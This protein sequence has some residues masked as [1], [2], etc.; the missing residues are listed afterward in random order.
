MAPRALILG[1]LV[2]PLLGCAGKGRVQSTSWTE[3]CKPFSGPVGTDV[4][5]IDVFPL[6]RP[7][8][9]PVVNDAVWRLADEFVVDLERK[10]RLADNGLRIGQVGGNTPMELQS[11]LH[12]PRSCNNPRRII[13][14]ADHPTIIKIG[15]LQEQCNFAVR[16]DDRSDE[17]HLEHA[18]CEF[19]VGPKLA[20]GGNVTLRFTPQIRHGQKQV[21]RK[22]TADHSG[23]ALQ[24]EE[25][26][27]RFDALSFDVSLSPNEFII[28]GAR[29]EAVGSLGCQFFVGGEE[30]NPV[31][32]L[33]AIRTSRT[34][35]TSDLDLDG[36]EAEPSR[37]HA[38]PLALQASWTSAR[39]R[40]D[41]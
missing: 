38:V 11:L 37:Q 36:D 28:V 21:V 1:L 14:H 12:S 40:S 16:R 25:P 5:H 4:V 9:D 13:M 41:P 22:P 24:E 20:T 17:V 29:F 30:A 23:W 6:E 15:A 27:E 31:Q 34:S 8:G 32:R 18:Q 35:V 7:L 26:V 10:G 2:V 33:L 19:E 3:R 39:G